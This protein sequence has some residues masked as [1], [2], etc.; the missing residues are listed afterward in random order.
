MEGVHK[1]QYHQSI[2]SGMKAPIYLRRHTA[3]FS[4]G[5]YLKQAG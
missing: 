2:E 1:F 3:A 4:I 5:Q